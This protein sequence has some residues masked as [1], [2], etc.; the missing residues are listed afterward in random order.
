MNKKT[1]KILTILLVVFLLSGCTKTLRDGKTVVT[2]NADVIC[3]DCNSK[4]DALSNRY[5]DLISKDKKEL[6]D[7]EKSNLINTTN[8]IALTIQTTIEIAIAS[9]VCATAAVSM[10]SGSN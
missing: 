1:T 10:S 5:N 6:N 4:C 3:S 7:E 9:V 8:N 2:Y